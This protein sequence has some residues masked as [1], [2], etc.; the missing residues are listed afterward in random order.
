MDKT[1]IM[2]I[3]PHR[4]DMLLIEEAYKT[5]DG[6]AEA[7]Y[8]VRGDEFFLRGHFPGYP[9][10]PGVILCEIIAQSACV[11]FGGEMQGKTPFYTGMNNVKFRSQV[12]PGD[13]VHTKVALTRHKAC[14]YFISGELYVGDRLCVQ[15]EFSFALVDGNKS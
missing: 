8:T 15:G 12:R 9:V 13:R 1:E 4:Q 3:L 5:E 7:Y 2:G 10:V 11:M 6:G 14:F